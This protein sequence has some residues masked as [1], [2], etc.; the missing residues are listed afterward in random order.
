MPKKDSKNWIG[1]SYEA[2]FIDLKINHQECKNLIKKHFS[3]LKIEKRAPENY[4]ARAQ[5]RTSTIEKLPI[6]RRIEKEENVFF[7]GA[8]GSR[9]FTYG[10]MIGDYIAAEMYQRMS[11]LPSYI[12]KCL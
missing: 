5:I 11:P 4:E 3:N 9:G 12:S 7:V 10:P 6:A 8:F 2:D 1:G